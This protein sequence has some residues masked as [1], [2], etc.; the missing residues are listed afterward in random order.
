MTEDDQ[1]RM[2]LAALMG[3]LVRSLD[4]MNPGLRARFCRHLEETHSSMKDYDS[5]PI[6]ALETLMWT[7]DYVKVPR[8]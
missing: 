8:P 3:V 6:R 4:E 1:T 7:Y 5:Q 2:A